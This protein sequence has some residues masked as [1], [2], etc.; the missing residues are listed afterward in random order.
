MLE[1]ALKLFEKAFQILEKEK[2]D[3]QE[4]FVEDE[5]RKKRIGPPSNYDW[6]NV[7]VFVIFFKVFYNVTNK[8]SGSLYVTANSFFHD[9]WVINDL[10]I[11]WSNKHNTILR[12]MAINMKSKY[13]KYWGSIE[14]INK[15]V[16][17][18]VLLDPQYKLDYVSFCFESI[19]DDVMVK[20]LV[21]EIEAYLMSLY[22]CYKSQ[23]DDFVFHNDLS[24]QDVVCEQVE[25]SDSLRLLSLGTTVET[26]AGCRV[27]SHYK[28]SRQ[29]QNTV[30]LRNDVDRY[31]SD[32][33]GE[34][35]DQ[36]DVLTWWNLNGVKYQIL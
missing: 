9:L 11:C 34:L 27:L 28:R 26:D 24:G 1:H 10:L 16:F 6:K 7:E 18:V 5:L 2:M 30:E 8:I 12:N 23:V 31:L 20:V 36:L 29:E 4:Y 13:D 3:Y 22:K 14:K 21:G 15:L 33:C 32:L 19:H 35:N 25:S 17:L